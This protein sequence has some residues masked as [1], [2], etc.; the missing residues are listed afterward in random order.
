MTV[1]EEFINSKLPIK[2]ELQMIFAKCE[3][4][5]IFDI[6]AC[7]G[8]DS[9]RYS[10]LFDKAIV[11]SFEPLP[12][13][14]AKCLTNFTEF[15]NTHIKAF[16]LALSNTNGVANFFISSG[17]PEGTEDSDWNFGNKSSSLYPPEPSYKQNYWL[18]FENKI[19]VKTQTITSFCKEQLIQK[20][21]FIH[22]DVQGAELNVLKGAEDKLYSINAI[23]LEVENVSMYQGQPLRKDIEKFMKQSGFIKVVDTAV[24]ADAGDQ[25]YINLAYYSKLNK[26]TI[27]LQ[28]ITLLKFIYFKLLPSAIRN[29]LKSHFLK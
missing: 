6:G 28:T 7:E 12:S 17:R 2:K 4:S 8:E 23:W 25:L 10:L 1:F 19:E 27:K 13:N 9:I 29:V 11:Y 16:Q 21:D 5:V 15:S 14:Y 20:I 22:M 18:K 24:Y 26:F 3:P